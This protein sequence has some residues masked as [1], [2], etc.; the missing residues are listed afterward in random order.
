MK[1][2]SC[3]DVRRYKEA[4]DRIA[5]VSGRRSYARTE[6]VKADSF[7]PLVLCNPD[8][9]YSELLYVTRILRVREREKPRGL[10]V[11]LFSG[12]A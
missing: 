1:K 3:G 6:I 11:F 2:S 10:C 12:Q 8:Y 7:P 9:L 4:K 5:G